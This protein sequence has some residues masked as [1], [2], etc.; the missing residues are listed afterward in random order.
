MFSRYRGRSGLGISGLLKK[1]TGTSLC[2]V[3]RGVSRTRLRAGP[4]FQQ[5]VRGEGSWATIL[6]FSRFGGLGFWRR[7]I[8]RFSKSGE[9]M[10]IEKR[11]VF[12]MISAVGDLLPPAQQARFG[13]FLGFAKA[14]VP[15]Y[16]GLRGFSARFYPFPPLWSFVSL[17]ASVVRSAARKGQFFREK[18]KTA[19]FAPR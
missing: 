5:A 3:F 15:F 14:V 4:L 2:T 13:V 7:I 1:G 6:D 9:R 12:S 17:C 8:S 11:P 16:R 18:R 10:S 19:N